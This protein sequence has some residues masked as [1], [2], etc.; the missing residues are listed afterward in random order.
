MDYLSNRVNSD[1]DDVVMAFLLL[2]NWDLRSIESEDEGVL[3]GGRRKGNLNYADDTSLTA[4]NKNEVQ[5]LTKRGKR[6]R[7]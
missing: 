6:L 5:I 4:E 3:V 2:T 1:F 7:H